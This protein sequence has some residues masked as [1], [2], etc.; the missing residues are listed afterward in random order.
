LPLIPNEAALDRYKFDFGLRT[1]FELGQLDF[2]LRTS[3]ELNMFDFGLRRGFAPSA[4]NT[5]DSKRSSA[6]SYT[7]KLMKGYN[8][9][10]I[11]I[12]F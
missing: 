7:T 10:K 4:S 8:A 12:Y 6:L 5:A 11:Q 1:T 9:E 3:F 2:G